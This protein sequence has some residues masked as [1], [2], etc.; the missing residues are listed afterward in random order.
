[1]ILH[2]DWWHHLWWPSVHLTQEQLN[3]FS[4]DLLRRLCH[5]RLI[6]LILLN[7]LQSLIE[8]WQAQSCGRMIL[9]NDITTHDPP[10]WPVTVSFMTALSVMPLFT[11]TS[12]EWLSGFSLNL[13]WTLCHWR[14]LQNCIVTTLGNRTFWQSDILSQPALCSSISY[15]GLYSK[16][17]T[18]QL[19]SK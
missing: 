19:F 9:Y 1:M 12:Q 14:L 5:L 15:L 2:S 6:H 18:D 11:L 3:R 17:I 13:L 16:V 8:T 4:W 7:F 10:W